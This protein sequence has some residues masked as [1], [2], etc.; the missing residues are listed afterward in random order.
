M[1]KIFLLLFSISL[2]NS[3]SSGSEEPPPPPIKYTL[4]T[5]ANPSE[6]GTYYYQCSAHSGMVGTITIE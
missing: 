6:A 5:V 4:T 2:I 1:K 3:C